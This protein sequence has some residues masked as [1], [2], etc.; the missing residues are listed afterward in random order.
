MWL[1]FTAGIALA[2]RGASFSPFFRFRE[3]T[4]LV[5]RSGQSG[6]SGQSDTF[7]EAKGDEGDALLLAV[8]R[9]REKRLIGFENRHSSIGSM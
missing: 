6:R 5:S 3:T 8:M 9:R 7:G 2:K 1:R 4:P